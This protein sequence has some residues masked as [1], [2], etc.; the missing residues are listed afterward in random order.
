MTYN[1]GKL[2]SSS[3]AAAANTVLYTCPAGTTA[4]VNI[5]FCNRNTSLVKV[6]LSIG[7]AAPVNQD[8]YEY[9]Q[10]ISANSILEDTAVVIG[11]GENIVAYSD[12]A[13]VS[14]RVHGF[15]RA[16]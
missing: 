7:A 6:R 15:E 2:G 11:A 13:N 12:T 3:L 4:T 5:R 8:F 16:A 9:D 14:V 1:S 10:P